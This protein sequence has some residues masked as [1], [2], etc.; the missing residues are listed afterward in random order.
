MYDGVMEMIRTCRKEFR[1]IRIKR[2]R[3]IRPHL[4]KLYTT[5]H[6]RQPP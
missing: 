1:Q 2:S 6:P 3:H 4:P 5:K